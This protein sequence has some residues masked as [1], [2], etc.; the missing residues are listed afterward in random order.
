MGGC[1][2]GSWEEPR[3]PAGAGARRA[4]GMARAYDGPS[5]AAEWP[6]PSPKNQ[7]RSHA[8]WVTRQ[9]STR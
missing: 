7:N 3:R 8:F 1:P 9:A 4:A 5:A 6:K 2:R